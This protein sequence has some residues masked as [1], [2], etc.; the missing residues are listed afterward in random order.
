[1]IKVKNVCKVSQGSE[2]CKYLSMAPSG[3]GCLKMDAEMKAIIDARTDMVSQGD[4][5]EGDDNLEEAV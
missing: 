5:C 4:N 2:C 3:W 1:M